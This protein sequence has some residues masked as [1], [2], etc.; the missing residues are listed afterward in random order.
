VVK[1]AAG[2]VVQ[3]AAAPMFS[4]FGNL[5]TC[6]TNATSDQAEAVTADPG[7]TYAWDG[8]KYQYNW[9]TKTL[10][11]GEYLIYANLADGTKQCV[12]ICLTK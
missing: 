7:M 1:N 3:Q 10:T 6:D 8:S 9:S 11:A 4:R 5:G 2:G 12:D